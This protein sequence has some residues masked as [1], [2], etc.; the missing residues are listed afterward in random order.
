MPQVGP[1]IAAAACGLSLLSAPLHAMELTWTGC[2]ISKKAFMS[3]LA[4]AFEEKTG[5]SIAISGGGATKGIRSTSANQ[6]TFGGSCRC[7]LNDTA[8]NAIPEEEAAE[9]VQVAWDAIVPIVHPDNPVNDISLQQLKDVFDGKITNW[10]DLGGPDKRII[11]AS[12]WHYLRRWVHVPR[13]GLGRREARLPRARTAIQIFRTLRKIYC[14]LRYLGPWRHRVSSARRS[15]VKII[16]LD[17]VDSSPAGIA[18]GKHP[19]TRPLY[20]TIAPNAP[21][22]AQQFK[23]FILSDYGQDLITEQGTVN[24]KTGAV[25]AQTWGSKESIFNN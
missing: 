7:A 2:G 6:S 4:K 12:K 21:T 13:L 3:E 14:I 25:L 22:E 17:G 8:G 15:S 1:L 9:F 19:L 24:L 11:Y 5:H 18:S 20:L 16:N 23:E 10:K